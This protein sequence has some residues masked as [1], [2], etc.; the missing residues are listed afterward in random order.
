MSKELNKLKDDLYQQTKI[1]RK[2]AWGEKDYKKC[3]ELRKKE[4]ESYEKWRLL[5][6]II[7]A[8]EKEGKEN[9]DK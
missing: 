7:K 2:R 8:N 4:Q 6:G 5:S 9:E 1:Q 3:T